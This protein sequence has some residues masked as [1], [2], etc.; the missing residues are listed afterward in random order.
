VPPIMGDETCD[1][2]AEVRVDK[3][4]ARTMAWSQR[5]T[6]VFPG[7]PLGAASPLTPRSG[8]QRSVAW[9]SVDQRQML[10][11]VGDGRREALPLLRKIRPTS[12]VIHSISRREVVAPP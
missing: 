10:Q 9:R 1:P 6:R 5:D 12:R 7:T 3:A 11:R 4:L 2:T 8:S